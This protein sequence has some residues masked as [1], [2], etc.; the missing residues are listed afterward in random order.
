MGNKKQMEKDRA[1]SIA[2]LRAILKPGDTVYTILNHVSSSGMMRR[3]SLCVGSGKDVKNITWDAARALGD[4][5]QQGGKYVQDAGMVVKGCGMDMG[6]HIVYGLSRTL[7]PDGF[8]IQGRTKLGV[9]FR[10]RTREQAT[11][12]IALGS[13]FLGRNGDTSGWDNDGGYALKQRWL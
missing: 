11:K 5:I 1:E 12:H 4:P 8:G 3:I 13:T 2:T 10:P 7:F 9:K 6:F